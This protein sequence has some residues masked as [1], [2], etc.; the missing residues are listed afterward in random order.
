MFLEASEEFLEVADALGV[1]GRV[2]I[3]VI[4]VICFVSV[5]SGMERAMGMQRGGRR[6]RTFHIQSILKTRPLVR[7]EE[8]TEITH[9]NVIHLIRANTPHRICIIRVK[10][11]ST[12][13]I[14]PYSRC[15]SS[16]VLRYVREKI[17]VAQRHH[18]I[19]VVEAAVVCSECLVL[20]STFWDN[21]HVEW[22][23]GI[24]RGRVGNGLEAR[25]EET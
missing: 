11:E 1:S 17:A 16:K 3:G 12:W 9:P 25:A 4:V 15:G 18:S 7:R 24:S 14:L 13:R 20:G 21:H 22:R 2:S 6:V 10:R 23:R 5:S 19:A 8:T